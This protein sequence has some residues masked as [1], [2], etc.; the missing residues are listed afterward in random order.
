MW[1]DKYNKV[2]RSAIA[3]WVSTYRGGQPS[4]FAKDM[5]GSF[6][7]CCVIEFD[8]GKRWLVRFAAPGRAMNRDEKV[9]YEVST[10]RFI[11]NKTNIPTTE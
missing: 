3:K 11:N 9:L 5:C 10:M 7:W 4:T 6:N 8:D 1:V 2:G